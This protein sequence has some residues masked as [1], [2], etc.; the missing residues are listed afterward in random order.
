[1][2]DY[3]VLLGEI[4]LEPHHKLNWINEC[5]GDQ[6]L[7]GY[8]CGGGGICFLI[9]YLFFSFFFNFEGFINFIKERMF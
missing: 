1:M 4:C 8:G 2:L 5:K 6:R 3:I 9:Q 7:D